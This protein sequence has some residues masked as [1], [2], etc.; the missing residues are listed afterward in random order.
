MK[1]TQKQKRNVRSARCRTRLARSLAAT[2]EAGLAQL[3]VVS[4][5]VY[6]TIVS[7]FDSCLNVL[8]DMID[9]Q[10]HQIQL[11]LEIE[12]VIDLQGKRRK[13]VTQ[14]VWK[15]PSQLRFTMDQIDL[16]VG[17]I[18]TKAVRDLAL[19]HDRSPLAKRTEQIVG[20]DAFNALQAKI[21]SHVPVVF[22]V[23]ADGNVNV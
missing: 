5:V 17:G 14:F 16:I 3:G 18:G 21:H 6:P 1:E 12:F 2:G 15:F 23:N 4:C 11:S 22:S 19:W 8:D 20:R 10:I 9:D 7:S 13:R